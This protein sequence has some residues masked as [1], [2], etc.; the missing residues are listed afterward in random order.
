MVT[1]QNEPRQRNSLK[2]LIDLIGNIFIWAL[3]SP[4]SLTYYL[5]RF[6]FLRNIHF[7]SPSCTQMAI[8][9]HKNMKTHPWLYI[10]FSQI[11][12]DAFGQF[13]PNC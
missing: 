8:D 3:T 13:F 1:I 5:R 7:L 10:C 11:R 4:L 6:I 2:N 12:M 9:L